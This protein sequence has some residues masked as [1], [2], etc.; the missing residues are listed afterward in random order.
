MN[1]DMTIIYFA[2]DGTHTIAIDEGNIETVHPIDMKYMPSG[3]VK[4]VNG[5]EPDATGNV[6]SFHSVSFNFIDGSAF[7]PGLI[8]YHGKET[9][10]EIYAYYQEAAIHNVEC[11]RFIMGEDNT[12]QRRWCTA[13]ETLK[14]NGEVTRLRL[15]FGDDVAPVIMDIVNN[16]LFFD[17]DWDPSQVTPDPDGAHQMLVTDAS[18]HEVWETRTHWS[19]YQQLSLVEENLIKQELFPG[20]FIYQTQYTPKYPIELGAK[21]IVELNGTTYE[22]VIQ[23]YGEGGPPCLGNR[24]LQNKNAFE[25]TGEPYFFNTLE[26]GSIVMAVFDSSITAPETVRITGPVQTYVQM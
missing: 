17:P 18:G 20:M 3:I 9:M 14:E 19:E 11:C 25:D 23:E 2:E 10:A 15:H 4:T 6:E 5:V 13:T 26:P 16:K 7:V 21:C 24:Y 22:S 8:Q 12:M 1:T